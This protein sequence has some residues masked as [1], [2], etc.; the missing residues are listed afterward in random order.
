MTGQHCG[1][2]LCAPPKGER[3]TAAG[4]VARARV[5]TSPGHA[6]G[7]FCGRLVGG[8][9]RLPLRVDHIPP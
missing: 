1:P 9:R 5:R 2:V 6:Q 7:M 3:A 4:G 8:K